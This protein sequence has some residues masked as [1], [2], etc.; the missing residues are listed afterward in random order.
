[1]HKLLTKE[2]SNELINIF[3]PVRYMMTCPKANIKSYYTSLRCNT[4]GTTFF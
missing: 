3:T 1:M 2:G 4:D